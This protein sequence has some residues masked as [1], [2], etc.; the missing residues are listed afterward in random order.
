MTKKIK[1][2]VLFLTY[3]DK[4]REAFDILQIYLEDL[5][6]YCDINTVI[7]D[8]KEVGY[9]PSKLVN[10]F[11]TFI[12]GGN[13]TEFEF[14]GWDI[15]INYLKQ[16]KSDYD[17]CLF[18]NDSYVVNEYQQNKK[19]LSIN[20]IK[21]C[22]DNNALVGK[23]DRLD[24]RDEFRNHRYEIDGQDVKMWIRTNLF[25]MT[26]EIVDKLDSLVTYTMKDLNKFVSEEY[27]GRVFLHIA[28]IS[29]NLQLQMI[30]YITKYW[31][32]AIEICAETWDIW[33]MKLLGMMNEKFVFVKVKKLGY[34]IYDYAEFNWN[35]KNYQK[36][37]TNIH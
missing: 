27:R 19:L 3:G 13:N 21:G 12:M 31:H 18:I 32:S 14:S 9:K 30:A 1:L 16:A 20:T 5:N 29:I 26:K 17:V 11:K 7:I 4:Y 6:K 35:G 2:Q 8:N 34:S 24:W 23:C 15:G 36:E 22:L 28:D 10:Y 37:N 33:K 25:Y